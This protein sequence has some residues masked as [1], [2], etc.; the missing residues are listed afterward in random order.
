LPEA[1]VDRFMFKLQ[2]NYPNKIEERELLRRPLDTSV[3]SHLLSAQEIK[4][5]QELVKEIYVDERIIEYIV[6]IVHATRTPEHAKLETIKPYIECGASPRA[7]LA[8]YHAGKAHAFLK[9]RH[10]VT[11]DDIKR[12]APHVLAHRVM[13]SYLA[14]AEH[15]SGLSLI[16]KI[17]SGVPCP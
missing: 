17:I 15:I 6:N 4:H 9:R 12:V 10:F 2:V 5:A 7:T 3:L 14:E 16:Q 1:Q 13:L 8:L 11:P